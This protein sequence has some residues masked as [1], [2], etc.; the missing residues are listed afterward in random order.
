M[1]N[2]DSLLT[3]RSNPN[4]SILDSEHCW[5]S[6]DQCNGGMKWTQWAYKWKSRITLGYYPRGQ[7]L[8]NTKFDHSTDDTGK[9]RIKNT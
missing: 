8:Q 9:E 6:D 5:L 4:H 1:K 2:G 7:F 3:N